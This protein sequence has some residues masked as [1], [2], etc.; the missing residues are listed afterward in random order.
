M[1]RL[2]LVSALALSV[3]TAWGQARVVQ[4][5]QLS[6]NYGANPT[7]TFRVYWTTTPNGSNHLSNVWV[8]IDCQPIVDGSLGAWAPAIIAASPAPTTTAGTPSYPVAL[9]YRGF[10]L[11]GNPSGAFD[12]TVTVA[13]QG[14]SGTKFNW[15]VYATDYPPNATLGAS[16]YD[17]HGTPP[18]TV[19]GVSLGADVRTF[20]G[21]CITALT[22][23]TGCPGILPTPPAIAS[24]AALPDSICIGDTTTLAATSADAVEYNFHN[25]GW[26]SMNSATFTAT[27]DTSYT[28]TIRNAAG[29]TATTSPATVIMRPPPVP[30]FINPPATYCADSSFKITASAGS[31]SS[32]C[33]RQTWVGASHNPYLT[34]N[35]AAAG[36]DCEFPTLHCMFTE[37]STFT[38]H[39]PEAGS[40]VVCLTAKSRHGFLADTCITISATPPPAFALTSLHNTTTQSVPLEQNISPITYGTTDATTVIVEGLPAGMSYTWNDPTVTITGASTVIGAHSYTVTATGPCGTATTQGV[41]T[42]TGGLFRMTT[43]NPD[44][45]YIY[46]QFTGTLHIDWGDGT[47]TLVTGNVWTIKHFFTGGAPPYTVTG[48]ARTITRLDCANNKLIELDVTGCTT[49]IRLHCAM[50]LLDTLDVTKNT[51]LTELYCY[52]NQLTALDVTKNTALTILPCSENQLTALDVTQNTVLTSLSCRYNKLSALDVT[53]NTALTF[54]ECYNNLLTKLDIS[55]NAAL[56]NLHC[57]ENL[58]TALDVSKNPALTTLRCASNSLTKL[59][60]SKNTELTYLWC[61]YNQLTALDVR[62]RTMLTVLC[63]SSNSLTELDVTNNPLLRDFQCANNRLKVLDISNNTALYNLVCGGNQLTALDV[64][65]HL[66]L[67]GLNCSSNPLGTLDISH[68]TELTS[69]FCTSNGL[70]AL[71]VSKQTKLVALYCTNNQLGVL[72]VSNN[73]LLEVLQCE[74]C[75][76][77]TI[78]VSVCTKLRNFQCFGNQLTSLNVGAN[79][80]LT[81]LLVQTNLFNAAA[82]NA[83]FGTLHSNPDTTKTIYIGNNP[84]S[85]AGVGTGTSGCDQTIATDKG[86]T[87][88][89]TN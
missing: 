54:L 29:C 21:N 55:K 65:A 30:V 64:S 48:Q 42:V 23:L 20:S 27:T 9:P 63:C 78:D 76:L 66:A 72:D 83:L 10:Y 11:Q 33:F 1:K 41:V 56:I 84:R 79:P 71:D 32:Y 86:W 59:D 3:S 40:V 31:G 69:L 77:S 38:V 14:L 28:L 26:T 8:F 19:N 62:A 74:H 80:A 88:N 81:S 61:P 25:T 16:A 51:A 43:T 47:D 36:G 57:N 37:D 73:T 67:T 39:M 18:F 44:S 7:V 15:C 24:F 53:K 50:N 6:A 17:L 85:G 34:G 46:P 2:I 70:T 49:L 35:D 22:D 5:E 58:L 60:I 45:I 13:L 75:Q 52:E 82:L 68:N 4:V 12:A 89:T 87:V